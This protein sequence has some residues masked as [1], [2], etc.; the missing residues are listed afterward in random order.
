[1]FF[2][3]EL[4]SPSRLRSRFLV[5]VDVAAAISVASTIVTCRSTIIPVAITA[6]LFQQAGFVPSDASTAGDEI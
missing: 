6:Q 3:V 4:I 5:D 2:L 1:M